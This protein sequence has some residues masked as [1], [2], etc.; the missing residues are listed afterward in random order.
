MHRL[1]LAYQLVSL[2]VL[3]LLGGAALR[4]L[5][6][7]IRNL[8]YH[9]L[10]H[11][12]LYILSHSLLYAMLSYLL[13]YM[14]SHCISCSIPSYVLLSSCVLQLSFVFLSCSL[15]LSFLYVSFCIPLCSCHMHNPYFT[16]CFHILHVFQFD[17]FRL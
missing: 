7:A 6:V 14:L 4:P 15:S 5:L 3:C 16:I 1:D 11:S 17:V 2:L 10:S 9:I 12:L 13:V 8:A